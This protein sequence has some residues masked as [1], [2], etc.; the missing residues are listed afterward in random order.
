VNPYQGLF[1]FDSTFRPVP[2]RQ[3]FLGIKG[4]GFSQMNNLDRTTYEKTLELVQEGH[5]V[6]I[7]VHSRKE[8][9][10]TIKYLRDTARSE[11]TLE[12]F[13][14]KGDTTEAGY[15]YTAKDVQKSRNKELKEMYGFGFGMHHAGML[16]SDRSLIERSFE[17][18]Y[19][20]VLVCTATLAWGVNLPAYAVLIKGTSIYDPQKG[21]RVDLSIL[22]VLQIFG[23]AGRYCFVCLSFH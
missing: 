5:Q 6:M 15:T 8:T 1:F 10:K 2:L 19:L 23:R 22:D 3:H 9:F 21:G 4:K 12:L 17:K 7:F 18:G 14:F 13:G 16:R 20:N 11:G